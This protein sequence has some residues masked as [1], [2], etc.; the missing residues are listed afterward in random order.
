MQ[1]FNAHVN[2]VTIKIADEMPSPHHYDPAVSH[3]GIHNLFL[4]KY[5]KNHSRRDEAKN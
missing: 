5:P 4:I 2:S 1:R 3:E